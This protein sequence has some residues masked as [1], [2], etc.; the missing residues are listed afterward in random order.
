MK[1]ISKIVFLLIVTVLVI[2]C[3]TQKPIMAKETLGN[4]NEISDFLPN[5]NT[6]W[7]YDGTG[8]YYHEMTLEDI[9]SSDQS[10]YYKIKGEILSDEK[11][12]N[13]S[14]YLTDIRYI[15]S[16]KGWRQEL[17]ESKLLDSKYKSM[18]L[19]KFPIKENN[20]WQE[21]VLD[22]DNNKKTIIGA[23]ESIEFIEGEK[24]ITVRY[25]EKNSDYYEVRKIKEGKGVIEF[26]KKL[27]INNE[28]HILGYSLKDF[29]NNDESIE[30]EIKTF[31]MS[32]NKAWQNYYN[33]Q[34]SKIFDFI[35]NQSTLVSE[36]KAFKKTDNTEIVFVELVLKSVSK[37]QNQYQVEVNESFSITKDEEHYIQSSV[38][39]YTL[40]K[41]NKD[42]KIIKVD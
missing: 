29:Y 39:N 28:D 32:Y 30:Y 23:I 11:N 22:F 17:Q 12:S 19:L 10:V 2:S 34:E 37:D 6:T 9:I 21:K 4:I 16:R 26:E 20:K 36:I 42:Y 33:N 31:L 38:R 7:V 15:I 5:E 27:K 3:N 18:Y 24:M 41:E 40:V 8:V 35:D 1:S 25:T 13:H 14:D